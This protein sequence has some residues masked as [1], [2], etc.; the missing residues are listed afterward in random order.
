MAQ[1]QGAVGPWAQGAVQTASGAGVFP[2][3]VAT[4]G[5]PLWMPRK[6]DPRWTQILT[7]SGIT[8]SGSF[9]DDVHAALEAL[10]GATGQLDDLFWLWLAQNNVTDI[11]E[12]FTY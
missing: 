6:G 7:D 8:E 12:P 4:D 3:T 10:T 11:S 9:I 5:G 1:W 2:G